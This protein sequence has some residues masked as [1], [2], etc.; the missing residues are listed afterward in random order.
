MAIIDGIKV[1][2]YTRRLP[3]SDKPDPILMEVLAI[4]LDRVLSEPLDRVDM[5]AAAKTRVRESF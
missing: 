2:G 4:D 3:K 5:D 1:S